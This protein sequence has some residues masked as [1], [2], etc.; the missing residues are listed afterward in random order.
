MDKFGFNTKP[1]I[2]IPSEELT[3]SG[4][5]ELES[6]D[7]LTP[8]DPIDI[9]RVAIGQE[10]LLAPSSASRSAKRPPPS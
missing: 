2:D 6:G 7:V 1:A 3:T 9:A 4:I 8:S 10:R 5:V